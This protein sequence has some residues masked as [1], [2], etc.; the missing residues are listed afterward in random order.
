MKKKT[1]HDETVEVHEL[2]V[3]RHNERRD[4]KEKQKQFRSTNPTATLVY[5]IQGHYIKK[6]WKKVFAEET[7]QGRILWT[8]ILE[9]I[10]QCREQRVSEQRQFCS[11]RVSA[12]SIAES[13]NL[14]ASLWPLGCTAATTS[15]VAFPL[16]PRKLPC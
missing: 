8:D 5:D 12:R 13:R 2:E 6:V 3:H 10:E 15:C 9:L 11:V 4:E 7:Y 1:S 16:P 14:G